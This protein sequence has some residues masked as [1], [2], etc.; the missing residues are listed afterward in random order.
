MTSLMSPYSGHQATSFSLDEPNLSGAFQNNFS[1][2]LDFTDYPVD[3]LPDSGLCEWELTE[4]FEAFLL[5]SQA[6]E[7]EGSRCA[8]VSLH[9]SSETVESLLDQHFSSTDEPTDDLSDLCFHDLGDFSLSDLNI[10]SAM[11]DYLL[12]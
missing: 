3:P 7:P 2:M 1:E 12:G 5:C 11:I 8:A 6:A 4:D 9:G 10:S